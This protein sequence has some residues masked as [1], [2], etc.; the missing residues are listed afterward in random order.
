MSGSNCRY[1]PARGYCG[2]R[3]WLSR[4]SVLKNSVA[5]YDVSVRRDCEG[6]SLLVP[7]RM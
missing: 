6:S 3:E 4:A 7:G 5:S 1:A 2:A